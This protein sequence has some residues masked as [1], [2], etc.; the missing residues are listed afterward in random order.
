MCTRFFDLDKRAYQYLLNQHLPK[1]RPVQTSNIFYLVYTAR[2]TD[3]EALLGFA[4]EAVDV[5]P[6]HGIDLFS[7]SPKTW[8]K[9]LEEGPGRFL[10]EY[11]LELNNSYK[12]CRRRWV[13]YLRVPS[14]VLYD[15]YSHE[16]THLEHLAWIIVRLH[17]N[18]RE[19]A[20][21]HGII[22]GGELK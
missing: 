10:E 13:E 8:S 1:S 16:T 11:M 17:H 22:D 19:E 2:D 18:A 3:K 21:Y 20:I 14:L 7:P 6:A 9:L 4:E 15:S 12:H 5:N